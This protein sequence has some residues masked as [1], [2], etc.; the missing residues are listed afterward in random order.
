MTLHRRT[1]MLPV[2]VTLLLGCG[3]N[4][5]AS[6][7]EL[8]RRTLKGIKSISVLVENLSDAAISDG[9]SVSQIQTDVELRLR[10]AG[11]RVDPTTEPYLYVRANLLKTD[12]VGLY[13]Y[14]SEV[15]FNQPVRVVATDGFTVGTTW[16]VGTVGAIRSPNM[17]KRIRE[18]VGDFV[19]EFINAYLSVNPK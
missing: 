6:D 4:L 7:A 5:L 3:F 14:S 8:N 15:E 16:S 19:D 13:A 12:L 10:L 18:S 17:S 2:L 9:L 1:L 11:I